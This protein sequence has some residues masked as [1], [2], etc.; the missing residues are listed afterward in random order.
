ML[1]KFSDSLR[2]STQKKK[3][4]RSSEYK[5]SFWM[6]QGQGTIKGDF[7]CFILGFDP[8]PKKAKADLDSGATT[9]L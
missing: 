8:S 3:K 5:M 4:K 7:V 6:A 2:I 9:T 1:I